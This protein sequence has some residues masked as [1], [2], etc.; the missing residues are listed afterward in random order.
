MGNAGCR[1][2]RGEGAKAEYLRGKEEIF[3]PNL[4]FTVPFCCEGCGPRAATYCGGVYCVLSESGAR[5]RCLIGR[6]K[7]RV[8]FASCQGAIAGVSKE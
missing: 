6:C 5:A 4:V 8:L 2:R 1:A 7:C 3:L